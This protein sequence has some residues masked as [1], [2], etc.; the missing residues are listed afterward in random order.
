MKGRLLIIGMLLM[1]EFVTFAQSKSLFDTV[2]TLTDSLLANECIIHP[3]DNIVVK[4][5]SDKI[6]FAQFMTGFILEQDTSGCEK[7][8]KYVTHLPP[9]I[10]PTLLTSFYGLQE[11]FMGQKY[12]EVIIRYRIPLSYSENRAFISYLFDLLFY[13][14]NGVITKSDYTFLEE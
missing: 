8:L 1:S 12:F 2:L 13:V 6:V 5:P 4:P 11:D 3:I 7:K 14:E 10:E 9:N